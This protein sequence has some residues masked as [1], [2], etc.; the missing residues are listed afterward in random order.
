M[1]HEELKLSI[2]VAK[3]LLVHH[4]SKKSKLFTLVSKHLIHM[5]TVRLSVWFSFCAFFLVSTSENGFIQKAVNYAGEMLIIEEIQ[6]LES[7]EPVGILRLSSSK[8]F[9]E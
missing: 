9:T 3:L 5:R 1:P 6:V 4:L 8:V 7:P 2:A